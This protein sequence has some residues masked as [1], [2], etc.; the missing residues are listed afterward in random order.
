MYRVKVTNEELRGRMSEKWANDFSSRDEAEAY[1]LRT[2]REIGRDTHIWDWDE[3]D[4]G[5]YVEYFPKMRM[6]FEIAKVI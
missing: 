6:T 1:C 3:T 5:Y 2:I 4:T